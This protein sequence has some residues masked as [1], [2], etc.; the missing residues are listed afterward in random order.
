MSQKTIKK[1][2]VCLYDKCP[3]KP[4]SV[5]MTFH[6][7]TRTYGTF[8]PTCKGYIGY[9][10]K[11]NIY[12]KDEREYRKLA[13]QI[14]WKRLG[15]KNKTEYLGIIKKCPKCG[16]RGKLY[17]KL[18]AKKGSSNFQCKGFEIYHYSSKLHK[19]RKSWH[20]AFCSFYKTNPK[21]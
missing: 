17:K 12:Y 10:P 14:I 18:R 16:K 13:N 19:K 4:F 6:R 8:C 9:S 20:Y 1:R 15:I 5:V 11:F 3:S 7:Y 2:I 21:P